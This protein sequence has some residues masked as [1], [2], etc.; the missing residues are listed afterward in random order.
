[1]TDPPSLVLD[2]PGVA[3]FGEGAVV[4]DPLTDALDTLRITTTLYAVAQLQGPWGVGFPATAGAYFHVVEGQPCWL[5]LDD[6]GQVHR[7]VAGDVVLLPHGTGHRLTAAPDGAV[8]TVFDPRTWTP[9]RL[10]RMPRPDDAGDSPH[11]SG[12]ELVCGAVRIRRPA[13]H[14]LLGVLPA[15]VAVRHGSPGAEELHLTAKILAAETRHSRAGIDT[16][17]ARLGDVLLV[18]LLRIWAAQ[19]DPAETG[20]LAALADPGVGRAITELHRDPAAAWTVDSLASVA[21]MSRSGF[22]QR[23]TVLVGQPPLTY[24]AAWRMTRAATLLADPRTTVREVGRGVGFTSEA[25]FS[26]AFTRHHGMPPSRYR[27]VDAAAG[28][29]GSE[30]L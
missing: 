2:R 26:R 3:A 15:V 14:P 30:E 27:R 20:W 13:S 21:G 25:A 4:N 24:L 29:Q 22:A 12:T 23:F 11:D 6:A 1:M 28:T 19:H 18:Q 16:V 5:T 8:G 10:V 17:L 7:L 9:R